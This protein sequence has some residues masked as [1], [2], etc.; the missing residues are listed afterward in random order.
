MAPQKTEAIILKGPWKQRAGVCFELDNATIEPA[1]TIRYLGI[2]FDDRGKFAKHIEKMVT[3]AEARIGSLTRI[4]PNIGG[5]K[6]CKREVIWGT[7]QSILLFGAPI[8][9]REMTIK[10]YREMM[11]K[12]QRKMLLRVAS[13]YRTVS[14]KAV[15][16]ITGIPP[17]ELLVE[18]RKYIHDRPDGQ[19]KQA[20]VVARQITLDKW[21]TKWDETQNVA[22]WTKML[23]PDVRRWVRCNHR[24]IDY[25]MSQ[26]LT[27]HGSFKLFAQ[28]IGK[29]TGI[30]M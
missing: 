27:D 16:V 23:I 7:V 5:P 10:K 19:T 15:Q 9:Y 11:I 4:M 13:A 22:Q 2:N 26:I 12:T 14:T 17:I 24:N 6:S 3:K 18:E 25:Y 30:R 8:W 29:A 28:H 20:K 1:R 21:Q